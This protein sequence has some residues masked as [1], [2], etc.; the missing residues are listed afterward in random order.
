[1]QYHLVKEVYKYQSL[2]SWFW[3]VS[4]LKLESQAPDALDIYLALYS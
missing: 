2:V 3:K 1:M 4:I